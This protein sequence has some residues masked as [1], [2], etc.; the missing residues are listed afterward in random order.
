MQ[1]LQEAKRKGTKFIVI[2]PMKTKT[3]RRFADIHIPI[4]PSTDTALALGVL[5]IILKQN[6]LNKNFLR[7]R[8]NAPFLVKEST[9]SFLTDKD[10]DPLVWD[11][12]L[13]KYIKIMK[14]KEK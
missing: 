10:G 5:R 11:E 2:D 3:V 14:S 7:E 8:T 9:G 13:E 4:E 1:S 12:D 6:S